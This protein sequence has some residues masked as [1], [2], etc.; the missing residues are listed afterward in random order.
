LVV[1]DGADAA[2]W[3]IFGI[4]PRVDQRAPLPQ[5]VPTLIKPLL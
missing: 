2:N 4:A 1:L 5:Q 3:S